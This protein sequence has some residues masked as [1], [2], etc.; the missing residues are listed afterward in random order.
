M[1]LWHLGLAALIVYV[2]L[3]RRRID[4]RFVLAGAV[5]PDIVDTPLS[6]VFDW[7]AGRG[8]A[9]TLVLTG[10]LFAV[11]VVGFSGRARLAWFGLPVGV[12]TH[13]A[14]DGMWASPRT[15]FWPAFGTR[16]DVVPREPY[17]LSL[18]THPLSHWT[19]WAGELIGLAILLWFY[20]AFSLGRHGRLR[21]FFSDGY[22]RP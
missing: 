14:A 12:L 15:F 10:V 18:L 21:L 1:Y 8:I 7:A 6:A 22:L 19:T 11:V 17:S 3:G 16:F 4:Y 13:L 5:L 9:H 2:T 20:V